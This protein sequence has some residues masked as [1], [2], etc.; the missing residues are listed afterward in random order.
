MIDFPGSQQSPDSECRGPA[1][2]FLPDRQLGQK[3]L[4]FIFNNFADQWRQLLQL[5]VRQRCLECVRIG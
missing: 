4:G 1:V 5:R 3:H 2:C